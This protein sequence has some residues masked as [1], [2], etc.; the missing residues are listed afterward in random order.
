MRYE[1]MEFVVTEVTTSR[2]RTDMSGKTPAF[3]NVTA[4]HH[5]DDALVY[6]VPIQ[7]APKVGDSMKVTVE[8][9]ED[10]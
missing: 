7:S 10:E 5:G 4:L 1:E 8:W 3:V 6:E 2:F 9:G